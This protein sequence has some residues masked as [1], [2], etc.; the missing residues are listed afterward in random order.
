MATR[1]PVLTV[2]LTALAAKIFE[3]RTSCLGRSRPLFFSHGKLRVWMLPP[4]WGNLRQGFFYGNPLT[5]AGV[6]HFK[7]NPYSYLA[8]ERKHILCWQTVHRVD[9]AVSNVHCMAGYNTD[10]FGTIFQMFSGNSNEGKLLDTRWCPSSLA[11][12]VQITSITRAY[13][14]YIIIYL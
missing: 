13:D 3:R 10:E 5:L 9:M 1:P 6:S 14:T 2:S 12:L 11:K 4:K 7:T 8:G